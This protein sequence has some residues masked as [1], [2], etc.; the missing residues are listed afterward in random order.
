MLCTDFAAVN[1]TLLLHVSLHLAWI[2]FCNL[3]S[4]NHAFLQVKKES[5][6]EVKYLAQGRARPWSHATWITANCLQLLFEVKKKNPIKWA[7]I[8]HSKSQIYIT[9]Q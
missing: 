8:Y 1:V 9:H 2:T 4:V 6:R 5:N 3:G 7:H